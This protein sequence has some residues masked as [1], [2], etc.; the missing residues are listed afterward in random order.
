MKAIIKLENKGEPGNTLLLIIWSL[1]LLGAIRTVM[2]IIACRL[3]GIKLQN[4][5]PIGSPSVSPNPAPIIPSS[6]SDAP[7]RSLLS[8]TTLHSRPLFGSFI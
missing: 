4:S 8:T 3:I 2:V 6:T 1:A 7:L 5:D